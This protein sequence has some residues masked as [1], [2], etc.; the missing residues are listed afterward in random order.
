MNGH[1]GWQFWLLWTA[2]T[3]VAAGLVFAM[4]MWVAALGFGALVGAVQAF[5]LRGHLARAAWWLPAT[6]VA[7]PVGAA[8]SFVPFFIARILNLGHL[9]I[10]L[11]SAAAGAALAVVQMLVLRREVSGAAWWIAANALGWGLGFG[12]GFELRGVQTIE[13]VR[14]GLVSGAIGGAITGAAML[15]LLRR[16]SRPF[17]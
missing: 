12:I 11:Y 3:T 6:F 17:P 5:A 14:A 10:A 9:P 15:W 2:G 13:L 16:R 7:W 8:G 1:P 4:N